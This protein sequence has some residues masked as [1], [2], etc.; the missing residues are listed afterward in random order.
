MNKTITSLALIALTTVAACSD[1]GNGHNGGGHDSHSNESSGDHD[2]MDHGDMDHMKHM[3]MGMDEMN[4]SDAMKSDAKMKDGMEL[5][6]KGHAG[7]MDSSSSM[8]KQ[9][10]C[11]ENMGDGIEDMKARMADHADDEHLKSGMKMLEDG[12]K[13]AND[14]MDKMHKK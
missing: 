6:A 2:G 7:M 9:M 1:S 12:L 8:A 10:E 14:E 13:K 5:F 11:L 3:T 4:K